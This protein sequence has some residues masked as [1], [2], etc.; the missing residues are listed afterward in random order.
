MYRTGD[1]G[2]LNADG[3][4]EYLGRSDFQVKIR[5]H[6]IELGEIET[7]LAQVPGVQRTVVI[8]DGEPGRQRLL[9]FYSAETELGDA[10]K[11]TAAAKLPAFMVPGVCI[12]LAEFPLSPNGKIDRRQL[13]QLAHSQEPTEAAPGGQLPRNALE[14]EIAAIWAEHLQLESIHIG[15]DFFALGGHSLLATQILYEIN[16]RHGCR[17]RL[18]DIMKH[19]TVAEL[20]EAVLEHALQDSPDLQALLAELVRDGAELAAS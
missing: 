17:L 8:A 10:L 16:R 19:P 11:Q 18:T 7:V 1:L 6:R 4:V 12:R 13:A 20:A 5:G 9:A 15:D 14:S 3:M 2:R